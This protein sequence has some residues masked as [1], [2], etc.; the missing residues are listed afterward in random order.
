M[1]QN[2]GCAYLSLVTQSW[3]ILEHGFRQ[4]VLAKY[5]DIFEVIK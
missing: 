1:I 4:L 3:E 5:G 2:C